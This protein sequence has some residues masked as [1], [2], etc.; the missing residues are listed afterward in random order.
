MPPLPGTTYISYWKKELSMPKAWLTYSL[1]FIYNPFQVY[2]ATQ[3]KTQAP[4][5]AL[6]SKSRDNAQQ[7]Q[8]W[9]SLWEAQVER[10]S[11]LRC[12][13]VTVHRDSSTLNFLLS[14]FYQPGNWE[15]QRRRK[16]S[17]VIQQ[18]D[19]EFNGSEVLEFRHLSHSNL[20]VHRG[21]EAFPH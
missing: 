14:S 13:H 3:S 1:Q 4:S 17:K 11:D 19:S 5:I 9:A 12:S 21:R 8:S 20:P 10:R 7:N 16:L 6:A 15:L 18:T 2:L